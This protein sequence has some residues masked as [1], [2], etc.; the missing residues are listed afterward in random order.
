MLDYYKAVMWAATGQLDELL[1]SMAA[2]CR[3]CLPSLLGCILFNARWQ[4]NI[5]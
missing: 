3:V 5:S 2:R 4:I 1:A